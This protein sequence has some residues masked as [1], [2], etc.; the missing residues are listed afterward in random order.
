MDSEP[1]TRRG[2]LLTQRPGGGRAHGTALQRRKGEVGR[3]S[4]SQRTL[5]TGAQVWPPERSGALESQSAARGGAEELGGGPGAGTG[6]ENLPGR[7]LLPGEAVAGAARSSFDPR[8]C[9]AGM[10]ARP[11][12][13]PPALSEAGRRGRVPGSRASPP[14]GAAV[15]K[16]RGSVRLPAGSGW[17]SEKPPGASSKKP[18]EPTQG[19][20]LF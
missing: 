9:P 20:D 14:G 11:R 18:P 2:C 13:V 1:E 4:R 12:G 7:C 6:G 5:K 17:P 8:D 10:T 16:Q 3:P 15:G 19:S